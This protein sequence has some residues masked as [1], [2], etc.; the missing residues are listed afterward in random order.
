MRKIL[1]VFIAALVLLIGGVIGLLQRGSLDEETIYSPVSG[2]TDADE[3]ARGNLGRKYLTQSEL[4]ELRPKQHPD[5]VKY[6]KKLELGRWAVACE[7]GV[8]CIPAIGPQFQSVLQADKWLG[9]GNLVLS[10]QLGQTVKAYPLRIIGWH[11][12]VNDYLGDLPVVVTYCPFTGAGLAYRRPLADGRP[13]KFG[14][15]GRLYNANILLYDQET[16]SFWQQFT[17]EAVAGPLLGVVG[18]L[19]RVYADIVPWGAWKRWHPGGEVLARPAE[20]E[21]GRRK[22]K[23][24]T[25]RYEEYPY[26]EYQ[27]RQWV[28]YGVDVEELDL[29]GLASKRRIIGVEVD[30]ASK[31]YVESELWEAS[32]INDRLAG[33]DILV[34][35]TPGEEVKAF[36]RRPPSCEQS[37]EFELRDGQLTDLQTGTI[38]DF[39]GKP[40]RGELASRTV[41]LEEIFV[42]PAYWFAWLLFRPET[43]LYPS[44]E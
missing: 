2:A 17:G 37:V 8:E 4:G 1:I 3:I 34:A 5:Q 38:W 16:G 11:Q 10:V 6:L 13:L 22:V 23:V 43:G 35:L 44:T 18:R 30:Q 9:E 24:S 31:A 32:V 12:A 28:G 42:T 27:L 36:K 15:S 20:V 7:Q 25:E 21:F 41:E 29:K 33:E 14:I 19:E 40:L 39:Q 26:G